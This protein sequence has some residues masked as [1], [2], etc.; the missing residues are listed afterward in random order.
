MILYVNGDS[1][2]NGTELT[3]QS[4]SWP[5]LL[6]QALDLNLVNDSTSGG[7]NP[8][9]LR[10][11]KDALAQIDSQDV[12][13]VVGWTGWERE[14]WLHNN[15]YY[16]VTASGRNSVP[17]ELQLKY[18]NWITEQNDDEQQRKSKLL[19]NQIYELHCFLIEQGI[20]HLFFNALM[21][22]LQYESVD[23]HNNYLGPYERDLSYYWYLLDQGHVPSKNFHHGKH[24]QAVWAKL[25]HQYIIENKLL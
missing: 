9:I 20:P 1:N 8:G 19:H 22:F 11:T 15:Q 12:F 4:H 5:V 7:N 21:P 25:L 2:S 10:T 6:G 17:A 13:V 24:A 3:D 14:E 16:T 23:W 18:V